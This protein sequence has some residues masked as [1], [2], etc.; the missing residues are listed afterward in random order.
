MQHMEALRRANEVRLWLA[1]KRAAV[2]AGDVEVWVALCQS[3]DVRLKSVA[4]MDFLQWL[5][6]VGRTKAR[7]IIAEVFPWRSTQTEAR[8]VARLDLA[9]SLRLCYVAREK[10]SPAWLDK[11][12]A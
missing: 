12:A 3:G 1:E 10:V 5:P 11:L 9:T 2:E 8:S 6:G 4:L 7:K